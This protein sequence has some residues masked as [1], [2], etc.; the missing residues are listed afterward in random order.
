MN[1]WIFKVSEQGKYA[2]E[3][4]R[5]YVYDNTHS[6]RV[7]KSDEFLYLG[8]SGA[9]YGLTGA[10]RVSRVVHR[11]AKSAERR[12]SR[13]S[14]IFAAHLADIVWFAK[15]FDLSARTK[16]GRRNRQAVGLPH[17]LNSVGW[18]ISMP[19]I[20]PE[21]FMRLLDAALNA[22]PPKTAMPDETEW[23]VCDSWALARKRPRMQAF[24]ATVLARHNYTCVVC[25]TRLRS[26]L[27]AAHVRSYAADPEQRANPANG[28]CLCSFCHSAFDSGELLILS[29]GS[30]QFTS[31]LA[32]EMKDHALTHFT[33][34]SAEK[35]Q[36][37]LCGVDEHFLRERALKQ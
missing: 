15:P 32:D 1:Y 5:K 29:D 16:V 22:A 19:G 8:K 30:L 24:R 35:R 11:K 7:E 10:G 26:A 27:D 13:V 33:T 3:P 6:V 2:D 18:S 34:V 23:R 14:R 25:G 4:G 37:W 12:S 17:D 28:I 31:D 36:D 21:L 20:R 9:S